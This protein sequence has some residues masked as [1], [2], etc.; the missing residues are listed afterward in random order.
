MVIKWEEPTAN[1][2]FKHDHEGIANALRGRPGEWALVFEGVTASYVGQIKRGVLKDYRPSGTFEAKCVGVDPLT[3]TA[4]K[5]Y[6]RYLGEV[7]G[8]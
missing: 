6:A 1:Q 5:I 7:S 3:G 8:V 4:E 2:R